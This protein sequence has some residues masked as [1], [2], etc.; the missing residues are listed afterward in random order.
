LKFIFCLWALNVSFMIREK[1]PFWFCLVIKIQNVSSSKSPSN[2]I[3][4]ENKYLF[5]THPALSVVDV[6]KQKTIGFS[7]FLLFFCFYVSLFLCLFCFS[8]GKLRKQKQRC[9]VN[10]PCFYSFLP[11][12]I[13]LR[14]NWLICFRLT[15]KSKQQSSE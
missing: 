4:K 13:L 3:Q 6:E 15:M 12:A 5:E 7:I 2:K 8:S 14:F 1:N 10:G 11:S 9:K